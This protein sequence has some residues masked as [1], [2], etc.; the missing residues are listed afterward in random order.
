MPSLLTRCLSS[1]RGEPSPGGLGWRAPRP[2][3]EAAQPELE[4][5][6]AQASL[7][8][9]FPAGEAGADHDDQLVIGRSAAKLIG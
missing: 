4:V 5:G 2:F 9:V 1:R 7:N 3:A 8:E 6:N